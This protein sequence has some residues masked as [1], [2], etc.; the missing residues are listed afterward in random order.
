MP[1]ASGQGSARAQS[2]DYA[3]KNSAAGNTEKSYRS[4]HDD[5]NRA[6]RGAFLNVTLSVRQWKYFLYLNLYEIQSVYK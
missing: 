6:E 2:S 4:R 5:F 1:C 3:T